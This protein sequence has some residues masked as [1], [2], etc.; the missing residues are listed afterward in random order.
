MGAMLIGLLVLTLLED[1]R[2]LYRDRVGFIAE[3]SH[4]RPN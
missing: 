3:Y 4:I 1:E 2:S